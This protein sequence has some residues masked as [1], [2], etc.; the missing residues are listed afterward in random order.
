MI[1]TKVIQN[2]LTVQNKGWEEINT[3]YSGYNRVRDHSI[4]GI[5]HFSTLCILKVPAGSPT[6]THNHYRKKF[7]NV[8]TCRRKQLQL[9]K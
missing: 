6:C 5:N 4:E 2:V 9:N 7:T 8:T 1:G 3:N